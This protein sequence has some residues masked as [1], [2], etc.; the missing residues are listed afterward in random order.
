MFGAVKSVPNMS[1]PFNYECQNSI[2]Q[3]S[4][5]VIT[6]YNQNVRGHGEI[7]PNMGHET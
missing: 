7:V 4:F 6:A 2:C 3:F 1:R 5:L